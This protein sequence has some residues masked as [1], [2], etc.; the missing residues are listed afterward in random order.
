MLLRFGCKAKQGIYGLV[1]IG[2]QKSFFRADVARCITT[3]LLSIIKESL[4]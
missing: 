3:Y 1:K 2:K 4:G